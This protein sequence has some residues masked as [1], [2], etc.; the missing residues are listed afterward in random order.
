[1]P[2]PAFLHGRDGNGTSN[3]VTQVKS[4]FTSQLTNV[5]DK[6]RRR[7]YHFMNYRDLHSARRALERF[8]RLC[9]L[10]ALSILHVR[11]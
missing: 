3:P 10:P 1:M 6:G 5:I 7:D 8:V 9:R 11:E 2:Q 4:I